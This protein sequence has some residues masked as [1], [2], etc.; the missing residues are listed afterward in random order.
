MIILEDIINKNLPELEERKRRL[1]LARLKE[2]IEEQPKLL[3]LADALSGD[4][5]KL[6]AE[7][8]KASPSKGVI[9]TDFDA[10][11]I[12]RTYADYGASAISV[13]TETS[14]FQGSLDYLVNIASALKAGEY[15]F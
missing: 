14:Y 1:P 6:I 3:S 9:R 7:V 4:G 11:S 13:L 12:A 2:L 5:V 10:V 8:K 15:L